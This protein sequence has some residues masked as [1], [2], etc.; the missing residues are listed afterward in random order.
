MFSVSPWCLL[1]ASHRIHATEYVRSHSVTSAP[2]ILSLITEAKGV[3]GKNRFSTSRLLMAAVFAWSLMASGFPG[4]VLVVYALSLEGDSVS[5]V[6]P[7]IKQSTSGSCDVPANNP[8]TDPCQCVSYSWD[9]AAQAGYKLP[10]WGDAH[11]WYEGALECGYT[12]SDLPTPGAVAVWG[13][14]QAGAWPPGHVAWV[15]DVDGDR[16]HVWHVNWGSS[17]CTATEAWFDVQEGITFIWLEMIATLTPTPT[18]T[19]T[20]TFTPSPT[21]PAPTIPPLPTFPPPP[22]VPPMPTIPATLFPSNT[23]AFLPLVTKGIPVPYESL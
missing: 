18:A 14:G 9:R 7:G 22:T 5:P 20:P 8:Y 13:P 23:S 11:L 1:L 17:Y 19:L 15:D 6:A 12:V 21:L 3:V 2:P 10:K 4:A 16:F